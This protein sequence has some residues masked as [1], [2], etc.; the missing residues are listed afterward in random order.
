[1][2][3]KDQYLAQVRLLVRALPCVAA[4][5]CFALKGGTAI[6]LFVRDLPRLSVDIDL[7]Y[8]PIQARNKSLKE[9]QKALHRI[10]Q[11][12]KTTIPGC[13]VADYAPPTQTTVTKLIIT[14]PDQSSIKIEVTPVLRGAIHPPVSM[15]VSRSVEDEFGFAETPLLSLPDLYAGKIVAA[16]DRQHPRD[17][18]DIH[19]L[20]EHSGLHSEL[21]SAFIVYLISH[22][23]SPHSLLCPNYRDIKHSFEHSFNGMTNEDVSLETLLA[24]RDRL[25]DNVRNQMPLSHKEFLVSFY[26][27]DPDWSLLNIE[28]AKK[29]PAVQWREKNLD[30]AG[31][32][33][34]KAL[35]KKLENCLR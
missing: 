35:V 1:M 23:H 6:N 17:L 15:T 34:R 14:G 3:F 2:A 18:F 13:Q 22:N 30:K 8:L 11:T 21:R 20:L 24:T 12:I 28:G 26:S 29:L 33:T 5:S 25:V 16:L 32:D 27:R 9:I 10:G 4:E 7:V 19:M 31:K